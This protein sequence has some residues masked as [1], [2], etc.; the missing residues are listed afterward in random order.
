MIFRLISTSLVTYVLIYASVN[1]SFGEPL[2]VFTRLGVNLAGA[3]FGTSQEQFSD[4][5]PGRHDKDYVYPR[6]KTME[7]FSSNNL[8]LFRIP[9]RTI[10]IVEKFE[11]LAE[12]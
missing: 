6:L 2:K 12:R 4:R 5:N 7:Y 10:G 9:P 11:E 3:E 1:N 8:G